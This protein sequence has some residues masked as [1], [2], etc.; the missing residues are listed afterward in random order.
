MILFSEL[1]DVTYGFY[2][3]LLNHQFYFQ[4]LVFSINEKGEIRRQKYHSRSI[5]IPWKG[6]EDFSIH[7]MQESCNLPYGKKN[8]QRSPTTV[9][10]TV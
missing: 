5:F 4:F 8:S 6:S 2:F 9:I 3:V 7:G 10:V 1:L